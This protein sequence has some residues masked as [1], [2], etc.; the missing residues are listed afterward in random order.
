MTDPSPEASAPAADVLP[1][2][3]TRTLS[4]A[5]AAMPTRVLSGALTPPE[6]AARTRFDLVVVGA[7]T[8]GI[9]GATTAASLGARVALVDRA[10]PGGDCLWT[11]C[12]PSKTLLASAQRAADARDAHAYGVR[13]ASVEVD[14]PAVM[15]RVRTTIAAIE[16]DDDPATLAAA[17]VIVVRG[18][19]RFAGLSDGGG[20]LDV[21][22]TALRF[23]R[24]LVAT[25]ASPTVPDLPGLREAAPL[26]SETL[27]DLDGL[28]QRLVVLGGGPVGVE[29]AQAFARLGSAVV[30]VHA[31]ERLLE[32]DDPDA[33]AVVHDALVVDGVDV[34]MGTRATAVRGRSGQGVRVDLD[35][36][37]SRGG[38]ATV[39]GTHLLLALG[40]TPASAGLGLETLGVALDERGAVVVDAARRT[41][42]ARVWAAGDVTGPP[43]YT[44][45]AGLDASTAAANAVLGLQ[46]AASTVVPHVTF[47]DPEVASV[48]LP[49]GGRVGGGH[50]VRTTS[51]A[52]VDR[53]VTAGQTAGFARL[54]L[55]RR[56][57]V[58]G[59]TIVS[60]RAGE[61]LGEMTV[62]VARGV[63]ASQ[64]GSVQH[65]YPTFSDGAWDA[66]IADRRAR[67][68]AP[69]T[70][71][72]L[73]V[74]LR[75]RRWRDRR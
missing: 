17:G 65:A 22:G 44:H 30:L 46:L 1:V 4:E 16:P 63:T 45:T 34:R 15:A 72:A 66:A 73:R 41:T 39:E 58:V 35:S 28:P 51:Q 56:G 64:L 60:P 29:T 12:V 21:D 68:A 6:Q 59:A 42:S 18:T 10:D 19:A 75:V 27:W 53:A 69:T 49:T 50:T 62:A 8:A 7:G 36:G 47:T 26:T 48:G 5:L 74:L 14:F 57:R 13:V 20:V 23:D 40:R 31:G 33:S 38:G 24:A 3:A 32:G 9:V 71:A 43:Y 54:R 55:D 11:G 2:S 70:R 25:G 67:L 52:H 37:G 61:T